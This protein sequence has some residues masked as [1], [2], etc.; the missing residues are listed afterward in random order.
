LSNIWKPSIIIDI[1]LAIAEV[2]V[3]IASGAF[4]IV[5]GMAIGT[6]FSKME[7]KILIIYV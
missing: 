5:S 3:P 7:K 4:A 2:A 6:S 1:F